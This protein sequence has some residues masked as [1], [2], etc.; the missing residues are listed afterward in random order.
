MFQNESKFVALCNETAAEKSTE[1]VIAL[2]IAEVME[3]FAYGG[4][5]PEGF[6]EQTEPMLAAL[7]ESYYFDNGNP[8]LNDEEEAAQLFDFLCEH[9][10]QLAE[11]YD[12]DLQR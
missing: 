3:D 10:V 11:Q 4:P 2:A 9:A 7:A 12:N 5:D 1:Q 8:D 6:R